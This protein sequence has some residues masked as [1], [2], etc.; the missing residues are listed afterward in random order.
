MLNEIP[1][2]VLRR[3]ARQSPALMETL[4]LLLASDR[5]ELTERL[6]DLGRRDS[7]LARVARLL[8]ELWRRLFVVGVATPS[9]YACPRLSQY[10]IADATG[11]TCN[12]RQSRPCRELRETG[13]LTFRQGYVKFHDLDRLVQLTGFEPGGV[14]GSPFRRSREETGAA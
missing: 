5:A 9:G 3:A 12:P 1:L 14:R 13:L 7:A 6:V 10:L 2:D 8:L 11:L 4:S